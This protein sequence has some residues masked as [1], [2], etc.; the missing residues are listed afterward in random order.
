M[1]KIFTSR[2]R[3]RETDANEA[4]RQDRQWNGKNG[5]GGVVNPRL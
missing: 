4:R 1:L 5:R 2:A 3:W